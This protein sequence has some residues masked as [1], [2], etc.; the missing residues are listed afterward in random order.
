MDD[1]AKTG[2]RLER[3]YVQPVCSPTRSAIVSGRWPHRMG[4]QQFT[5]IPPG[6]TGHLPTA[7]EPA[8]SGLP[9]THMI[10]EL[11]KSQG[12]STHAIGKVR[13]TTMTFSFMVF[14][15]GR[16]LRCAR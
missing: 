8:V 3:Y 1:L 5:T 13:K 16:C 14:Y 15:L 9:R 12:Y 4:T 6:T 10:S 11:L 7:D 2:V